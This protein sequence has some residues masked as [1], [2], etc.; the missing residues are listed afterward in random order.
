MYLKGF[1]SLCFGYVFWLSGAFI[2]PIAIFS[3]YFGIW[4]P[5]YIIIAYYAFRCLFPAQRWDWVRIY[6]NCDD[7]PY[8][9]SAQ[10]IFDEG[11]SVPL[12]NSKTL[13]SVAPHG[14][15]TLGWIFMISSK[16]Y[17][18]SETKWLVAPAM[19]YLP[20]IGDLMRWSSCFSCDAHSMTKIMETGSNI[21]LVPGG[22]QEATVYERKKFRVY[23]ENRKGFIKVRIILIKLCI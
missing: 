19:M 8:C 23:F 6:F 2:F 22:F 5:T 4:L 16:L 3:S 11:A 21:G 14:I 12:P 13:V 18:K 7:K 17:L 9:R 20:F 1:L 10:I 15:M